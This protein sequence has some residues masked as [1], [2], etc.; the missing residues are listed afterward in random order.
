MSQSIWTQLKYFRISGPDNWGD[1]WEMNGALL[2]VLDLLR[3]YI[4]LPIDIHEGYATDGHT[5]GSEH[6]TGDAVDAHVV[7][8]TLEEAYVKIIKIL[9]LL[10]LTDKV[11]LGL[12]PDW[13]NRGFHLGIK[14]G[15]A[16][17]CFRE[18]IQL[19]IGEA[20]NE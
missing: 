11:S 19:P 16:R 14:K 17:W 8:I 13:N 1:P 5:D 3:H 20:F 4:G 2:L 18:G 10:Q 6:Y 12:Y 15:G 7:G 9:A